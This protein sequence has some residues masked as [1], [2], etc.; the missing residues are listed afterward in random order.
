[1]RYAMKAAT[2]REC[3]SLFG[4]SFSSHDEFNQNLAEKIMVWHFFELMRSSYQSKFDLQS[5]F[6][7][8]E[9]AET[10]EKNLPASTPPSP[11][12]GRVRGTNEKRCSWSGFFQSM[13]TYANAIEPCVHFSQ[14]LCRYLEKHGEDVEHV[15]K[16]HQR[17]KVQIHRSPKN[18]LRVES[19]EAVQTN[20]AL[21]P[22]GNR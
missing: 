7:F 21:F 4:V 15:D 17:R 18:K 22:K 1:M 20:P 13:P 2:C 10:T 5:E 11:L 12:H 19:V 14:Q 6:I 9:A 3:S 16:L 8:K